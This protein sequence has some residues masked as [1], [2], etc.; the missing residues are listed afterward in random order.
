M[1]PHLL[2]PHQANE[3]FESNQLRQAPPSSKA[4]LHALVESPNRPNRETQSYRLDDGCPEIS[5]LGVEVAIAIC[6]GHL[7]RFGNDG[8][9]GINH[10]ELEHEDP[11]QAR[12]VEVQDGVAFV[13][14]V[15]GVEHIAIEIGAGRGVLDELPRASACAFIRALPC[16]L[17]SKKT[18]QR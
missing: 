3:S 12:P 16:R 17:T 18:Q 14:G 2:R 8:R 11:S 6:P 13:C 9:Y 1:K 4:L 5:E 10:G 7:R 15:D